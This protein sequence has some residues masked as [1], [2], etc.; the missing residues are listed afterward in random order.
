MNEYVTFKEIVESTGISLNVLHG[1][2]RRGKLDTIHA[3]S[4]GHP[5]YRKFHNETTY[6]DVSHWL[7]SRSDIDRRWL[8]SWHHETQ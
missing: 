1:A 6:E 5:S 4:G 8:R 7:S 2:A 3:G